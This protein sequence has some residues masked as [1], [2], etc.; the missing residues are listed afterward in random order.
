LG[1]DERA[2]SVSGYVGTGKV[3]VAETAFNKTLTY[4]DITRNHFL[5][6]VESF[7]IADPDNKSRADDLLDCFCYA[8]AIGL[9]DWEGF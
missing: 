6:Q 8:V 3:K 7:S 9:G 5:S 4:K 2:L 1:K